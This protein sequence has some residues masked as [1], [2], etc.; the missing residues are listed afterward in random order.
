MS[1]SMM[2]FKYLR[3]D[4]QCT[5]HTLTIRPLVWCLTINQSFPVCIYMF[6]SWIWDK[7]EHQDRGF[8]RGGWECNGDVL[9][10]SMSVW[11]QLD[12]LEASFLIR[13]RGLF[14]Y[15]TVYPFALPFSPA[16]RSYFLPHFPWTPLFLL[17]PLK[18]SSSFSPQITLC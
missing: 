8:G 10:F 9:A 18:P 5:E 4:I 14:V 16:P 2:G 12:M 13:S 15:C 6:C 3:K 7:E 1:F 11:T 17:L